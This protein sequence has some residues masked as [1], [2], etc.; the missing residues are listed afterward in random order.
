MSNALVSFKFFEY[1]SKFSATCAANSL[2]GQSTSDLGMRALARP[3]ASKCI[4]GKVK[5]AVLPVPVWAIPNT[6]LPSSA[7][8]IACN[9]MGVGCLYPTSWIAFKIFGF[10]F[11]SE[12]IAIN[13]FQLHLWG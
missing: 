9:C 4:I 6:S 11:R 1:S 2:V 8:G 12:N 13:I 7:A 10:N 5:L 3:R